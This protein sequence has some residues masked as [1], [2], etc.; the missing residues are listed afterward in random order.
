VGSSRRAGPTCAARRVLAAR[1]RSRCE[2][3]A[4]RDAERVSARCVSSCASTRVRVSASRTETHSRGVVA[5]V[6]ARRARCVSLSARARLGSPH[7]HG[8]TSRG[9][10]R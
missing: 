10:Q 5:V 1:R 9:A 7:R 3:N 2:R 4:E 8:S 6:C